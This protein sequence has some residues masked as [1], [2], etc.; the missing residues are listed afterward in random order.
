MT[1]KIFAMFLAVLMVASMLPT[2]VFAEG[3][4]T[5]EYA[6]P[7][8]DYK[9]TVENCEWDPEQ[10]I[11]VDPTC[12]TAG[13]TFH[14]CLGCGE[15]F[16]VPTEGSEYE[17]LGHDYETI[18]GL[19]ATCTDKG[20]TSYKKC[21]RCGDIQGKTEIPAAH[22]YQ[23]V[24]PFVDCEK[25]GVQKYV[26]SVCG[27]SEDRTL[28]AGEHSWI[29]WTLIQPATEKAD[30][31]ASCE[32]EIC[33]A[34][35]EDVKV[36]YHK[37]DCILVPRD[38][39]AATCTED[40]V[41][42]HYE[43]M[44]CHKLFDLNGEETTEKKL[45]IKADHSDGE[46]KETKK[47]T[48]LETGTRTST[49]TVCGETK[50]EPIGK[51]AHKFEKDFTC[52]E[53]ET[54]EC[55]LC[56]QSYTSLEGTGMV[57]AHTW[58]NENYTCLINKRTCEVC[59]KVE[60]GTGDH[61]VID[62]IT[63]V[64]ATCITTGYKHGTCEY[65]K[66]DISASIPATGHAYKQITVRGTCVKASYSFYI[67]TN[68][69][70]PLATTDSTVVNQ[71]TYDL[72][73]FTFLRF[74]EAGKTYFFGGLK[75]QKLVMTEKVEQAVQVYVEMVQKK[76]TPDY[77]ENQF[78]LFYYD[79]TGAKAYI[80]IDEI[81]GEAYVIS[82]N[83]A[84]DAFNWDSANH[85][86][87]SNGYALVCADGKLV[88]SKDY[89]AA[90]QL[91]AYLRDGKVV[92][93]VD[94]DHP[95]VV[96]E[97][98]L[99]NHP[100]FIISTVDATCTKDGSVTYCCTH[101][102]FKKV[103]TLK[104]GHKWTVTSEVKPGCTTAGKKVETC[105]RCGA[106]QETPVPAD[107]HE[108][109]KTVIA[110]TCNATGLIKIECK[111]CDYAETPVVLP[112][113]EDAHDYRIDTTK[114]VDGY[115]IANHEDHLY[116][117]YIKCANCGREESLDAVYEE[118]TTKTK[119][120]KTVVELVLDK[121]YCD[122]N[123]EALKHWP[124][125]HTEGYVFN[126]L[127]DA[128]EK[129][130][131]CTLNYFERH[132]AG[133]CLNYAVDWYIC[134]GCNE[135]VSVYVKAE[136]GEVYKDHIY[137]VATEGEL[138]GTAIDS[139]NY[140]LD[141]T[142]MAEGYEYYIACSR[143]EAILDK[144]GKATGEDY[145]ENAGKL[146]EEEIKKVDHKFVANP[147]FTP[148]CD[149]PVFK[150]DDENGYYEYCVYGCGTKHW[151]EVVAENDTDEL[152]TGYNYKIYR[153]PK[154]GDIHAL[155][156]YGNFGHQYVLDTE[157]S[158][159]ATC[160]KPGKKVLKCYFCG[161][162]QTEVL[163]QKDHVNA[164][165]EIITAECVAGESEKQDR[166]C[167]H[168]KKEIGHDYIYIG[169]VDA[170]CLVAGYNAY[171]C[172][173]CGKNHFEW[174]N[175]TEPALGHQPKDGTKV[176]VA[177]TAEAAGYTE[178]VCAICGETI[179]IEDKGISLIADAERYSYGAL[180]EVTVRMDNVKL[181][182]STFKY[183]VHFNNSFVKLVG[184][185]NLN[186]DL[187]TVPGLN[188]EEANET[189]VAQIYGWIQ[190][191]DGVIGNR[192]IDGSFEFVKLQ[193]RVVA[194]LEAD[195]FAPGEYSFPKAVFSIDEVLIHEFVENTEFKEVTV[196]TCEPIAVSLTKLGD[197]NLDGI[198]ST[199]DLY[200]ASAELY[201]EYRTELDLDRDGEITAHDLVLL[202]KLYNGMMDYEELLLEVISEEEAAL[203]GLN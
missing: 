107:G 191:L 49:C 144:D 203:L 151:A 171:R 152:C 181:L 93:I 108:M 145:K 160:E 174:L 179:R 158:Y 187:I 61:K 139:H 189:G 183:H 86:Y 169:H 113:D 45:V 38:E 67:C 111:N 116:A 100:G 110:A 35:R 185:E 178:Y 157:A 137:V 65:C 50:E 198:I 104:A 69:N 78:N 32:C 19:A 121:N 186:P 126:T 41:K 153:C 71:I 197:L 129:H 52:K 119:D 122:A 102:T 155:Y 103:I 95:F 175:E 74:E 68:A 21:T 2:S 193:F 27:E 149:S 143:C 125:C 31:L 54:Q 82:S 98:D 59:G 1:K 105:E 44:V 39:V 77:E 109:V 11:V 40:G 6:C 165:G 72:T 13:Y 114:G 28:E 133:D 79:A 48:C 123:G 66:N 184:V 42:A 62:W 43:C 75:D 17:A 167:I 196:N 37:H 89:D 120:G 3:T 92:L 55:T 170:T 156:F 81:K 194:D 199:V 147:K 136:N 12:T 8:K 182:M 142:C 172:A 200:L 36:F 127:E 73:N 25:G 124:Y 9:H 24:A 166:F 88:A 63:T 80:T 91:E 132:S 202:N 128:E 5:T 57:V 14:T 10:D 154:C 163:P 177:A 164:A 7:G 60:E 90:G 20:Y 140:R 117:T 188:L 134:E 23:P 84:G 192:E 115:H 96:G 159:D 99:N 112:I 168:C 47:A 97:K 53:G 101:C 85:C 87:V 190:L 195:M 130:E 146:R 70:C 34:K 16:A 30:G 141:P 58:D 26:C 94:E 76:D 29:N 4:E 173:R 118:K 180:V 18:D 131:G 176:K 51:L 56:K 46:W 64:E 162:A 15:K 106:T 148:V 135:K 150:E 83:K 161:D 22:K 138:K 33:G 201:G